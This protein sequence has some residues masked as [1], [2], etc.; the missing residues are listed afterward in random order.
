MATPR[1]LRPAPHTAGSV[2]GVVFSQQSMYLLHHIVIDKS[3]EASR[4]P[5][6][7]KTPEPRIIALITQGHKATLIAAKEQ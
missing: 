3:A 7:R 4:D 6:K 5:F 2:Q 1:F